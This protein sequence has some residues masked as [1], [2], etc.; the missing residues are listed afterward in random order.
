MSRF[1]AEG[2][3]GA[4][5]LGGMSKLVFLTSLREPLFWANTQLVARDAIEV[6]REMKGKGSQWRRSSAAGG[7]AGLG[8]LSEARSRP[9]LASEG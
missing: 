1:A 7:S 4:D 2:E 9:P 3:P 5:A 6:V 8:P